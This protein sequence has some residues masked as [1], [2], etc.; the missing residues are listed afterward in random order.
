MKR[1]SS[2]NLVLSSEG[3]FVHYWFAVV[4]RWVCC[5]LHGLVV[6]VVLLLLHPIDLN[7]S[8]VARP[9][10]FGLSL[11]VFWVIVN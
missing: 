9:I 6:V 10:L 3:F 2:G 5:P 11:W 1:E 8:F 7:P 4:N